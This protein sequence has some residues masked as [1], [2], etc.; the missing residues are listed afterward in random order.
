MQSRFRCSC[1]AQ[2]MVGGWWNALVS[3]IDVAPT[4]LEIAGLPIAP[5]IQGKSLL[6][7]LSGSKAPR[8]WA[9]SRLRRRSSSQS[10][11]WQTALRVNNMKLVVSHGVTKDA[12]SACYRLFDLDADPNELE[13]LSGREAHAAE[14]DDMID[15]LIDARCELEDRTEPRIAEF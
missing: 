11:N 7:V 5:R 8:G 2:A 6:G 10:R 1:V 3:T 12:V 15:R 14:L 13:D 4:I 9:L